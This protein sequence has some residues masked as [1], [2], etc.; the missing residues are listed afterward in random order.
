MK[1]NAGLWFVYVLLLVF[2]SGC[3]RYQVI[4]DHLAGQVKKE[5]SYEQVKDSPD[6]YRG[7]LV[8]WGRSTRRGS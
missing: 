1:T 2:V 8:V 4:P 7:K 6:A 3:N 5:L